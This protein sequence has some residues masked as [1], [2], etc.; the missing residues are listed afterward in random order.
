MCEL[1]ALSSLHPTQL[2]L[3]LRVLA[4]RGAPGGHLRDGWGA[5]FYDGRAAAL[6]R[7]VRPAGDSALARLL[8]SDG[9]RTR[10]ALAHIRHATRGPAALANT[11]PFARDLGGRTHVFA[12]N[13]DLPGIGADA[14]FAADLYSPTGETDSERAFCA[15]LQRLHP[16]WQRAEPPPVRE[17][18]ET[19]AAFAAELRE[20]GPAN[21]LYA[22]AEVLFAHSHRRIQADGHV[23]PPGLHLLSRRCQVQAPE[24]RLRVQGL[25]VGCGFQEVVLLASVPLSDEPWQALAEGETVAVSGGRLLMRQAAATSLSPGDKMKS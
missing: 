2:S 10:L 8:Q 17:R 24:E 15:L 19:V 22:D 20:L 12:H 11:Q 5:A 21:F 16:L 13:G 25:C 9:P 7:E 3:S 4:A 6:Y 14:R 23:A 18:L 1:L